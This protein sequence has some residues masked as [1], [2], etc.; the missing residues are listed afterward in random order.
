MGPVGC[1]IQ[2][3]LRFAMHIE[4]WDEGPIRLA[5][6]KQLGKASIYSWQQGY[7]RSK[8]NS[9]VIHTLHANPTLSRNIKRGCGLQE[10][11]P[12]VVED[13]SQPKKEG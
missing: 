12:S 13:I 8:T 7:L 4:K 10:T 6:K 5:V 2:Y 3:M 11:L 9:D 1:Y